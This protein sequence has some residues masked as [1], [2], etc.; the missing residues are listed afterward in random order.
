M[1]DKNL[2][3]RLLEISY[4]HK[5]HH[6]GS[7]FSSLDTLDEIFSD[8]KKEDIFILSNGHAAVSLY[9]ILEKYHSINA[10]E[11]LLDLG[12][13]PKR[14]EERK[15]Y[16]STGS[17]G[18]GIT[19]AVGRAISNP[20]RNVYCMISDGECYEGSVWEALHF[21]EEAKLDNLKIYVNANG[22]AAYREVDIE[23]LEQRLKSFNS[24][25]HFKRTKVDYF[26]LS[27]ISA[28]YDQL[29]EEQYKQGLDSL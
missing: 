6:L 25:I 11:L 26:G 2:F 13:H 23:N 10:E 8:M 9:V 18:M 4:K 16:C 17:L 27:G 19:V 22:Y 28:H 24:N 7:Y 29:T 12:E 15:I 3:K 5:L 21:A 14:D 1:R 20:K